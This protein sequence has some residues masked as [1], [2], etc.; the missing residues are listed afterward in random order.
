MFLGSL[1]FQNTSTAGNAVVTM[2]DSFHPG[3]ITFKN[4]SSAGNASFTLSETTGA[5]IPAELI[6]LD[7]QHGGQC[8]DREQSGRG[9]RRGNDRIRN[10]RRHRHRHR[11]HGAHHRNDQTAPPPSLP[12]RPP[13]M[14][15]SSTTMAAVR[16]SG[17]RARPPTPRSPTTPAAACSSANRQRPAAPRSH[18]NGGTV[19]FGSGFVFGDTATAGNSTITNSLGGTIQF[20]DSTTAGNATITT[21]TGSSVAIFPV[22]HRWS[23]A[24]HHQCGRHLRHV[25]AHRGRHDGGLDRGCGQLPAGQQGPDGRRQQSVHRGERSDFRNRRRADQG[26]Q[27]RA[28]AVGSERLYGRDHGQRRYADREQLDRLVERVDGER[29]RNRRRRRHLAEDHDQWRLALARQFDRHHR[30]HR[31]PLIRRRRQLHRRGLA[32]GG[33]QDQLSRARPEPRRSRAR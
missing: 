2:P 5:Q 11:R 16:I 9:H 30:D 24:L 33:R 31:Q 10:F 12:P 18:N 27:R 29:G 26:R 19:T 17:I 23:R 20:F 13:Q 22:Q 25:G 3:F 21:N 8:D 15:R 14:R 7:A 1:S 28:H 6:F 32:D 4:S